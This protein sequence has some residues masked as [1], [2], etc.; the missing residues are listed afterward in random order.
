MQIEKYDFLSKNKQIAYLSAQ[1]MQ[2]GIK[3]LMW[4]N[5]RMGMM[6]SIESRF[7]F[8][9]EDLVAFA[10]NLPI[11]FKISP[12]ARFYNFKH[13]FLMDKAIVRKSALQRLPKQ[14]VYKKK[15]GFPLKGLRDVYINPVYFYHSNFANLFNLQPNQIEFMVKNSSTYHIALLGAFEVWADLFLAKRPIDEVKSNVQQYWKFK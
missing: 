9:E 15:N 7:P 12:T 10:M 11:K 14:L 1:M 6:H 8:L 4:R 3:S 13:P 2:E 5:D